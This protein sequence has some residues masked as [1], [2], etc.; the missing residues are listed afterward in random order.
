MNKSIYILRFAVIALLI[1]ICP[2]PSRAQ[3]TH[4]QGMHRAP[5]YS[6]TTIGNATSDVSKVH[7]DTV[8]SSSP[9]PHQFVSVKAGKSRIVTASYIRMNEPHVLLSLAS[10]VQVGKAQPQELLNLSGQAIGSSLINTTGDKATQVRK[11]HNFAGNS[12]S[13]GF[14]NNPLPTTFTGD[15][16]KSDYGPSFIAVGSLR[17]GSYAMVTLRYISPNDAT[18]TVAQ[19]GKNRQ[20]NPVHPDGI[21]SWAGAWRDNPS[22]DTSASPGTTIRTQLQP[23][24]DQHVDGAGPIEVKA[25]QE[26]SVR[27]KFGDSQLGLATGAV[28][29][30]GTSGLTSWR[31]ISSLSGAMEVEQVIGVPFNSDVMALQGHA[32]TVPVSL[33]NSSEDDLTAVISASNLPPG[34]T[35]APVTIAVPHSTFQDENNVITKLHFAVTK[36]AQQGIGTAVTLNFHATG[37]GAATDSATALTFS[38][39]EPVH[40]FSVEDMVNGPL[41]LTKVVVGIRSDGSWYINGVGEDDS[42]I[43]GDTMII[44]LIFPDSPDELDTGKNR[45]AW[46]SEHFGPNDTH[47]VSE[48]GTSQWLSDNYLRVIKNPPTAFIMQ[49]ADGVL[50]TS[51]FDD[52]EKAYGVVAPLF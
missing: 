40:E 12:L 16:P 46:T 31:A 37:S 51:V 11:N 36:D 3:Q 49:E 19:P 20:D 22:P 4:M 34:V 42:L 50:N 8:S 33:N 44:G 10:R 38:V 13:Q 21:T 30:I 43:F 7:S 32:V 27:I 6:H 26:F 39:Y 17:P 9:T 2:N 5:A 1:E 45:V 48:T 14:N 28:T 41:H 52:I 25:G 23:E 24:R 35:M 29:V 15:L 18:V 47:A